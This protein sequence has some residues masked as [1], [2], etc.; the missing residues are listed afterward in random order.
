MD[1]GG[2]YPAQR[3]VVGQTRAAADGAPADSTEEKER[4]ECSEEGAGRSMDWDE[5]RDVVAGLW[6]GR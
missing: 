3:G 5:P 1:V 6:D 4:K 2:N